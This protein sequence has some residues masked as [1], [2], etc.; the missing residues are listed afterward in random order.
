[1]RGVAQLASYW[2]RPVF[3]W[4]SNDI[5]FRNRTIYSTLIR[6][7]GPLNK[8]REYVICCLER[9]SSKCFVQTITFRIEPTEVADVMRYVSKMFKWNRFSMI[10]DEAAPYVAVAVAIA[11]NKD[12][13]I[14]STH[15]VSERMED[16]VIE[17]IFQQVRKYSRSK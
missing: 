7:L 5:E 3:G 11:E 13:T 15:E 1:M 17:S 16:S 10:H 9:K 12:T 6:L 4:V 14:K 8:L 2:R